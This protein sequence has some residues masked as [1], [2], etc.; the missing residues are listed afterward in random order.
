[1][2]TKQSYMCLSGVECVVIFTGRLSVLAFHFLWVVHYAG[3]V[4]VFLFV[5]FLFAIL[6]RLS[7]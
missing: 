6:L 5:S 4:W 3:V 2:D 1:M 7:V